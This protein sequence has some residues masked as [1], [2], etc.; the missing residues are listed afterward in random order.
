MDHNSSSSSS[1]SNSNSSSSSPPATASAPSAGKSSSTSS[2][3][4]RPIALDCDSPTPQSPTREDHSIA[5]P[6]KNF[7]VRSL[8]SS[9]HSG[10]RSSVHSSVHS[11]VHSGDHAAGGSPSVETLSRRMNDVFSR[12]LSLLS[13]GLGVFPGHQ[14][15]HQHHAATFPSLIPFHPDLLRRHSMSFPGVHNAHPLVGDCYAEASG[16]IGSGGVG[17]G[18]DGGNGGST[19]AFSCVKC[20]KMFST[21]HGL[22]VHARRSHNGKRPFACEIC[23]KTFGH[24]ISLNQHRLAIHP[25]IIQSHLL[26]I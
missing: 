20:E 26:P 16:S 25:P 6:A 19:D 18:G 15:H 21:P 9:V 23:N 10:V 11:G 8:L 7:S 1:S 2:S 17:D 3:L 5:S 24:E 22:E 14:H 13:Y 4:W 12:R